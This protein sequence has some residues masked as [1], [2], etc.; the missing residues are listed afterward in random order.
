MAKD[1]KKST[2]KKSGE[3]R[4]RKDEVKGIVDLVLAQP[5]TYEL[6][7]INPEITMNALNSIEE[8]GQ[9][10]AFIKHSKTLG[11]K[12]GN[13]R[14]LNSVRELNEMIARVTNTIRMVATNASTMGYFCEHL[15]RSTKKCQ[16]FIRKALAKRRKEKE[17]AK[18]RWTVTQERARRTLE[19]VVK[20]RVKRLKSSQSQ[21]L[22]EE[23]WGILIDCYISPEDMD[24]AINSYFKEASLK[25]LADFRQY[26]RQAKISAQSGSE[27]YSTQRRKLREAIL[28][29]PAMCEVVCLTPAVMDLCVHLDHIHNFECLS[30]GKSTEEPQ[31]DM[32]HR[33][34]RSHTFAPTPTVQPVSYYHALIT[35]QPR[36]DFPLLLALRAINAGADPKTLNRINGP[37]RQIIQ[38][39]C[40][41][42]Q[43]WNVMH[44]KPS[45][46]A[47]K[48]GPGEVSK[49]DEN[50]Q[51]KSCIDC[52]PAKKKVR[53][54]LNATTRDSLSPELLYNA[55]ASQPRA[56]HG[57]SSPNAAMSPY[58]P[59]SPYSPSGRQPYSAE[60]KLRVSAIF[61]EPLPLRRSRQSS[62]RCGSSGSQS[63][64]GGKVNAIWEMA[65]QNHS[66]RVQAHRARDGSSVRLPDIQG[67]ASPPL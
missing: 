34:K 35:L 57:R 58:A 52:G 39:A 42:K 44:G 9:F 4:H 28:K 33:K 25:Y 49:V 26:R 13:L 23:T 12:Q 65:L 32:T 63:V 16:A 1:D 2:S 62:A 54:P 5:H 14:G 56:N 66:A 20:D 55:S 27:L 36:E 45:I 53:D 59:N 29:Y 3:R 51:P 43:K 19:V 11:L 22:L 60:P 40:N 17:F 37:S 61:G 21:G 30:L 10:E 41:L 15:L 50:G 48:E 31:V 24:A 46:T 7:Q 6:M 47:T 18:N 64:P 67:S 8:S 38:R